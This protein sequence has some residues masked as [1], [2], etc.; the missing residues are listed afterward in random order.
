MV[1]SSTSQYNADCLSQTQSTIFYLNHDSL[2]T[3]NP[4]MNWSRSLGVL[5]VIQALGNVAVSGQQSNATFQYSEQTN[6]SEE[7]EALFDRLTRTL[8][9]P[10]FNVGMLA[11]A[12][13]D[14]QYHRTEG[15]GFGVAAARLSARGAL[16][17][18]YS[19]FIQAEFL[20]SPVILDARVSYTFSPG[21]TVDAGMFKSPFSAEYLIPLPSIDF[22]NRSQVVSNLAPRRQIGVGVRGQTN[23]GF[24]SYRAG[25]FNGNGRRLE[26]NDNNS[27]M[28]VGRFK[29]SPELS[30]GLL[31]I[32][33]NLAYSD[34]DYDGFTGSRYLAGGD[35]RLSLKRLLLSSEAIFAVREPVNKPSERPLGYH[36]TLGYM[37]ES[38]RH[39]VLLRWDA[40]APDDGTDDRTFLIL[41]YNFWPSKAFEVQ[42]N[43]LIP[44]C[45]TD[46]DLHQILVNFQF[47]F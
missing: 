38:S 14:V 22:V 16:D 34:D 44:V 17:K 6:P 20:T 31:E 36:I 47:A 9:M 10:F 33:S 2:L 12:V 46:S 42:L 7:S 32:G 15:N 13:A 3:T 39:Q 19:Y 11:Q 18:G 28:Y 35:L 43:Y 40:F 45:A 41:G 25:V 37:L 26:G 5:F 8:K 21:M 30:Q 29:V 4:I 1:R 27:F 24:I 23:N